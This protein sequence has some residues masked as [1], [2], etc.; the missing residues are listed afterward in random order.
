[1][2]MYLKIQYEIN[3]ASHL[4]GMPGQLIRGKITQLQNCLPQKRSLLQS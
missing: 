1:M 2:K 4:T 3:N